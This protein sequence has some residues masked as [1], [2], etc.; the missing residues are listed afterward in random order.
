MTNSEVDVEQKYVDVLYRRLDWLRD[1]TD[2]ELR[3]VRRAGASGTPQARSER[4]AFATL[5]EDRL[6]QLSGVE[7]RLC[8]GRLDMADGGI[9]Y[10]G[11]LGLFD[12]DQ[13]QLLVDWRAPASRDFYQATSLRPG[14]VVRRRHLETQ[15]RSVAAI[16]DDVLDLDTFEARP[17]W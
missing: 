17:D 5:Y 9:W 8:F 2:R 3:A 16:Y 11:R 12:D 1:R 10:I 7:E 13:S 15:S 14:D 4:D 6:V